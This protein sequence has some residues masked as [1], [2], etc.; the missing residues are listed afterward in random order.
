ME[1]I[2]SRATIESC[3]DIQTVSSTAAVTGETIDLKGFEAL[4]LCFNL[5]ITTGV[6]TVAVYEGDESDMSDEALVDDDFLIMS[7][8]GN[9]T[10]TTGTQVVHIGYVGHKRYVRAKVTGSS[11]PSYDIAGIA[12]KAKAKTAPTT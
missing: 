8:D 7:E 1:D 4:D 11:T 12:Y 6:A 5:E 10:S 2:R 9:A 3:L